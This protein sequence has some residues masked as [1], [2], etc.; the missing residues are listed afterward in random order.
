LIEIQSPQSKKVTCVDQPP[1][2]FTVDEL[3]LILGKTPAD[4]LPMF[5]SEPLRDSGPPKSFAWNGST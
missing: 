5:A 1:G 4:L 2:I 3:R